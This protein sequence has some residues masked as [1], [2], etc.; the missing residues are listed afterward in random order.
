MKLKVE[1]IR[2]TTNKMMPLL[3]LGVGAFL[4]IFRLGVVPGGLHQDE[5]FVAWNAFALWK[6]GMD[7]A[8]NV[9][10]V[11]LAD[12]GDGHSAL[13][14]WILIPIY[15]LVGE[16]NI[17]YFVTRLPQALM[18][19]LTL[20][21]VYLL[22]KR[23]FS[24][25]AG[26]WGL[27]LL[28][29]CPWHIT[30]CRWGLDANLAPAFLM[31][32]LYFFVLS[33]DNRKM[34]LISALMYGL[35]LY[36]YAVIWPIVPV[37]LLLQIIYG[38]YHKKLK[39]DKWSWGA[40]GILL[41]F[42]MPLLLFVYVNAVGKPI[43]LSFMTIPVMEG[44]RA[45]EMELSL[46]IMWQKVRRVITLLWRQNI[47]AVHDILLPHGLFYDIGRAF[48]ILGF[49]SLMIN[50]CKKVFKK[51]FCYEI[52][53]FI[54]LI[55]ALIVCSLVNANLHQV[56]CLFIPLV[57]LE[58]YG[59]ITIVG[60][61]KKLKEMFGKIVAI[62]LIFVY[63]VCLLGFQKDYYGDYRELLS[64]YYVE[65]MEDAVKYAMDQGD[66]IVVERGAQWPRVLFFSRTLPSE[67]LKDVQIRRSTEPSQFSDGENTFYITIDYENIDVEKIYIFYF[68]DKTLFEENFNLKQ[69]K[70][71]YV[72]VPKEK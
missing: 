28:A 4:R 25:E 69:F 54:Q 11:Y 56:N 57:L 40:V 18:G 10:P 55:G 21:V 44:Y 20:W 34:L 14:S 32:G 42:A 16:N 41:I 62:G 36:S 22:L 66:E 12:W 64:S 60:L 2:Q 71:W 49:V 24:R 51:I 13:Y 9:W 30:M 23:M 61:C 65:G 67:Y 43:E 37:M 47:G 6:E 7:S 1:Q 58:T 48:I 45:S 27:F 17:T 50:M 52:F 46:P 33:F 31:F 19:I 35:S 68:P 15:M 38:L 72:A 39:I 53:I 8:G 3:L 26:L 63:I 70:E 5:T 59:V 29:I